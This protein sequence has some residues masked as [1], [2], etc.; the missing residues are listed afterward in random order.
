MENL[1]MLKLK[2]GLRIAHNKLDD[3]IAA[4]VD[5]CLADLKVVGVIYADETDPLI[6]NAIK[7][8]CRSLYTDDPAKSAEYLRRYEALKACLMMAEGYGSPPEETS[9]E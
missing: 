7:L 6:F 3:D 8:W 5:A 1:L 4:D 2:Q 9:D